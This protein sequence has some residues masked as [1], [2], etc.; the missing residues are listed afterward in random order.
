MDKENRHG[1][2]GFFNGFILGLLVGAGLVFLFGTS[3][4]KRVLQMLLEQVEE[5]TELSEL[6]EIPEGEEEEY[7]GAI[8]EDPDMEMEEQPASKNHPSFDEREELR[9]QFQNGH[10]HEES[11]SPKPVAKVKRFFR[12]PSKKMVS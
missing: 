11:R 8:E 2:S 12:G 3:K 5:N 10:H 7:L 6:L 9:H 1:S 4:G